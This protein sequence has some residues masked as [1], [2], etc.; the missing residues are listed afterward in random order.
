LET[1]AFKPDIADGEIGKPIEPQ[2]PRVL[3]KKCAEMGKENSDVHI[4]PS[5]SLA[6]RDDLV[7]M[8]V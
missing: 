3:C 6:Y 7:E 8:P 2:E 1:V 5:S 4:L